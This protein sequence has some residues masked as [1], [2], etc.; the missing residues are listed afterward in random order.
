MGGDTAELWLASLDAVHTVDEI[1]N[2]VPVDYRAVLEAPLRS[3]ASQVGKLVKARKGLNELNR[4]KAAGTFPAQV[5]GIHQPQFQ[6]AKEFDEDAISG[7]LKTALKSSWEAFCKGALDSAIALFTAEVTFFESRLK[8]EGWYTKLGRII[9]EKYTLRLSEKSFGKIVN[10]FDA[11]GRPT[12][13]KWEL[14]GAPQS[15]KTQ[16]ERMLE[17][18]PTYLM[19][20]VDLV[21]SREDAAVA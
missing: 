16:Y 7:P 12:G 1:I 8:P 15:Y 2:L 11:E 6:L 17:D 19:C 18:A 20:V 9:R 3:A 4:H 13:Q 21:I 10:M 5:Q 14:V